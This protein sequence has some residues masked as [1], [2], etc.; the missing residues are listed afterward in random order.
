MKS[1]GYLLACSDLDP[2]FDEIDDFGEVFE[3]S[4]FS[5]VLLSA[6]C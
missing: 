4:L 5:P 1:S 2:I 6:L 3:A